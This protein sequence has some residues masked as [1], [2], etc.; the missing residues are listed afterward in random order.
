[1]IPTAVRRQLELLS[2]PLAFNRKLPAR[3]GSLAL[4][5]SPGASLCYY[6]S[7]SAG[8]WKDLYDFAEYYVAPNAV[9]WDVGANMGVF[10]FSAAHRAGSG[11]K[12]L[13][14]EPDAW[15]VK[16]L[17]KSVVRNN[18]RGINVEILQ[19]AVSEAVSLQILNIPERCR[20]ASHLSTAGGAGA[21]MVGGIREQQLV[22]SVSLDWLAERHSIPD[23]LKIDVDG[24]ELAVLLGGDRLLRQH[25]PIILIEVYERNATLVSK[26]F[27][28]LGYQLFDFNFGMTGRTRIDRA[29]Y[30]TLALPE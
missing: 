14:L 10:T 3:F 7:L 26:L 16:L 1:M 30:N 24:G 21:A 8:H 18:D 6:K 25:R 28:E 12:V 9:V 4:H 5:V 19:V 2:R 23:V 22:M 15:S 13:A 11:G 17:R 20:A 29:V 27:T